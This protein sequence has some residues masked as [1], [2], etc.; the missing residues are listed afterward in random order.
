MSGLVSSAHLLLLLTMIESNLLP[1]VDNKN[2]ETDLIVAVDCFFT[3]KLHAHML[4]GRG[5]NKVS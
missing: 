1:E 4:K 5:Y 3:H 2:G